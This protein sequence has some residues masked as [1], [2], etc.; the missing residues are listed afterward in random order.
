MISEHVVIDL[1]HLRD[2]GMRAETFQHHQKIT[3]ML[4]VMYPDLYM[5]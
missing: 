4:L 2:E 3:F 5:K 1:K